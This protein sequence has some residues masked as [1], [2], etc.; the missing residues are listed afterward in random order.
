MI[1][2]FTYKNKGPFGGYL[3]LQVLQ[4][5]A[6][7]G[8]AL[9]LNWIID[10]LLWRIE[11][12]QLAG[13]WADFAVCAGYAALLGILILLSGLMKAICMRNVMTHLREDLSAGFLSMKMED[14]RKKSSAQYL[15]L[16]NQNVA[17]VE[18][19]YFKNG[20]S[21]FEGFV[22][23]AIAAI[24]LVYLNPILALVSIALMSIPSLI[25]Q[26][27]G[28][29]LKAGQTAIVEATGA[30]NVSI[31]D[32]FQG[33]EVIKGYHVEKEMQADHK[34]FLGGMEKKKAS[35]QKIMSVVYCFANASGVAVQFLVITIAG[36]L[37]VRGYLTL[38]SIIA[39]TQLTGQVI[40]PVF[41]MSAKF[42]LLRSTKPLRDE[43]EQIVKISQKTEDSKEVQLEKEL[44][45]QG[46][47]YSYA[48]GE[49]VLSGI[50]LLFESGKH[51]ALVGK[52]GSGKSTLLQIIG[53]YLEKQGGELWVDGREGEIPSSIMMQ[54][55]VFLF[56]KTL[57]ENLCLYRQ[58][59]EAQIQRALDQAGLTDTVAALPEGMETCVKENGSRFSGGEK[60]RIALAR[61]ILHGE[62]LLLMDE[63]TSALDKRTAG[64]IEQQ[65][66][67]CKNLT[68]ISVT[69]RL[70]PAI[71][72]KYDEVIVLD[73]GQ[74]VEKGAYQEL[75][76]RKGALQELVQEE[77]ATPLPQ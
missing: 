40:T 73:H 3:I 60:Q 13:L 36:M 22:S 42:S 37:A 31:K 59:D 53:G 52:S 24:L 45:L 72:E 9:L 75:L 25:P 4:I 6:T 68:L 10:R 23:M 21:I 1:K 34:S 55:N 20:C 41:Q 33:F 58:F 14:F 27:F 46:I 44:Q 67:E 77:E 70:D 61:A 26:L 30:Y 49:P 16:M 57:K 56:D 29:K 48:E 62:E 19:N 74:V 35:F 32:L 39:L 47:S 5:A 50:D 18:E 54:Q 28:R 2:Y 8:V 51:Y 65:L 7:I 63:A 38:G 71:L 66:S 11:G 17:L 43:M 15:S 12:K 64:Q 76:A 69:H